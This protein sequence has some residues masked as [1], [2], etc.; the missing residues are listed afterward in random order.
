MGKVIHFF[1]FSSFFITIWFR[2]VLNGMPNIVCKIAEL[3]TMAMNEWVD[4]NACVK[5]VNYDHSCKQC[6]KLE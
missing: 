6:S 3:G 2:S 1:K 5:N 4:F